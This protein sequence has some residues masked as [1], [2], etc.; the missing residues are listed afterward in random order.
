MTVKLP[1]K[2]IAL[3]AA[4]P[5]GKRA[6]RNLRARIDTPANRQRLNDAVGRARSRA[7]RTRPSEG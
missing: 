4:T 5:Q 3:L 6:I 1:L 2:T 7:A